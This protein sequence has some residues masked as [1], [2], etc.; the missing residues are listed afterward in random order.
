LKALPY[1]SLTFPPVGLQRIF[2]QPSQVMV[3]WAWLKIVVDWL[4]PPHL[5]SMKYE[6]GAGMSLL[7][8]CFCFSDS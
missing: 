3:D 4:H 6:F 7:S 5:T 8:L 1:V 2:L